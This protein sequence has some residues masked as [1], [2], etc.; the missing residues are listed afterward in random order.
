MKIQALA[1][2]AATLAFAAPALPAHAS[3][4]LNRALRRSCRCSLPRPL[5]TAAHG[6]KQST[7][8][9]TDPGATGCQALNAIPKTSITG[10]SNSR[11][12]KIDE[13]LCP[14]RLHRRNTTI[15]PIRASKTRSRLPSAPSRYSRR[16]KEHHEQQAEG[17]TT[18]ASF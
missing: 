11:S 14:A 17:G 10:F 7:Q 13:G 2:A 6:V 4:R 5:A 1:V 12:A 16:V 15:Q 8:F 3:D 18:L 9:G